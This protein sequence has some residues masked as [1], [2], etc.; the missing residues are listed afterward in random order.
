MDAIEL[1]LSDHRKVD[2]IFQQFEKGGNSDEFARLF[3]QLKE[4]L[5]VHTQIEEEIFYPAARNN[6][7]TANLVAEA[8]QEQAEVKNL[9]GQVES[10]DNTSTEWGQR[11]TEI[12]R[13]VQAHVQMEETEMFPKVRQAF[14]TTT[15]EQLGQ[16]LQQRKSELKGQSGA[17]EAPATQADYSAQPGY[18][19]PQNS[20][21]GQL[22]AMDENRD[23]NQPSM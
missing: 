15:L 9:L 12:M 17:T 10:M 1:L 22:G 8:Y 18:T 7:D 21:S 2:S 16:Q 13:D 5:T 11:M 20:T 23:M 19:A 3:A 6:P 4:E 14:D